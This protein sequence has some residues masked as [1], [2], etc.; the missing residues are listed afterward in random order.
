MV[1]NVPPAHLIEKDAR[2]SIQSTD[3]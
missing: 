2:A 3:T 1:E